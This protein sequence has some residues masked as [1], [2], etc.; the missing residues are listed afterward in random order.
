MVL[1]DLPVL[2]GAE[3]SV[4]TEKGKQDGSIYFETMFNFR[5]LNRT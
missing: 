3:Y 4:S 2:A 1:N 5:A